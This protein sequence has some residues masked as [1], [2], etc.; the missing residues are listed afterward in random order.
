MADEFHV[1]DERRT[2]EALRQRHGIPVYDGVDLPPGFGWS[3][4]GQRGARCVACTPTTASTI[5]SVLPVE[6]HACMMTTTEMEFDMVSWPS[7]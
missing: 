1:R 4:C 3:W 5:E 2:R 6:S 7:K